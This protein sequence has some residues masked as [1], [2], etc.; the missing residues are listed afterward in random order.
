ME[1]ARENARKNGMDRAEFFCADASGAAKRLASEGLRPDVILVD[2]P[3]KGC[4][5][6]V[7]DAIAEMAPEKVIMISCNPSTAARD[8]RILCEKGYALKKYQ[9]VDLFPRTGHVECVA[10]LKRAAVG[11]DSGVQE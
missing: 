10:L 3:R 11:R 2:P 6:E 8:C 7:L 4:G 5:P 1:N 9:G